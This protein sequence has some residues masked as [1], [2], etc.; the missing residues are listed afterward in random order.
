MKIPT[1]RLPEEK[2]RNDRG[3]TAEAEI[4]QAFETAN[5][6]DAI[7]VLIRD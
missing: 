7:K 2:N 4:P 1:I 5:R 3:R 6:P